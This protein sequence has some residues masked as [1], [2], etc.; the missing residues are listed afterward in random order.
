MAV[1]VLGYGNLGRSMALNLRD[2]GLSVVVGN[3]EDEYRQIAL[4]D[5]LTVT[6]LATAVAKA[7][8]VYILLPDEVIP[9]VYTAAVIPHLRPGSAICFGSGYVLA[10]GLVSP[11]ADADVLLLAP[12]CLAKRSAPAFSTAAG[13]L[14][15]CPSNRTPAAGQ[16]PAFWP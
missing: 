12:G 13:S 5:G 10:F 7:D 15:T 1:A 6:G 9:D 11:A 4:N 3:R 14:A 2:S 16:R 8:L